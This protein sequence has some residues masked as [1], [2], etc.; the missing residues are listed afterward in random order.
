MTLSEGGE[1]SVG[2]KWVYI[3]N[4]RNAKKVI[5]DYIIPLGIRLPNHR[6]RQK[7]SS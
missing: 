7:T 6:V 4:G 3:S 1:C 2:R 5:P